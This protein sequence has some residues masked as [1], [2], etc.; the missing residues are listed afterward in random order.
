M[1]S[2][3]IASRDH[4][5]R[6]MVCTPDVAVCATETVRRHMSCNGTFREGCTVCHAP[7]STQRALGQALYCNTGFSFVHCRIRRALQSLSSGHRR[8]PSSATE[9]LSVLVSSP[10]SGRDHS[11]LH[12][13]RQPGAPV[14]T[15][16]GKVTV[17]YLLRPRL[18]GSNLCCISKSQS[19]PKFEVTAE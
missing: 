1:L 8:S 2:R 7:P 4:Q 11:Y 17:C 14:F 9:R 16:A 6:Q 13:L 3:L 5:C 12:N 18:R 10:L 19:R 15:D